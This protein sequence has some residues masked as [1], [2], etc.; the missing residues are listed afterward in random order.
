MKYSQLS[1]YF[2]AQSAECLPMTFGAVERE[3]G[4][5][6]PPSA[7]RYAAWW[8]NDRKG[9][10]QARAWL[11]AGYQTEQVDM[12]SRTLVFRRVA[13]ARVPGWQDGGAADAA[14]GG[15]PQTTPKRACRSPLFGALKDSF[16]VDPR[17]DANRPIMSADDLAE[18]VANIERTADLIEAGLSR[19]PK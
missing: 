2:R 5:L 15:G 16:W 4:V 8:A 1:R 14:Q 17:W 9:H 13:T 3:A 18:M 11:E 7:H 6:L 12:S 10:A 19:K